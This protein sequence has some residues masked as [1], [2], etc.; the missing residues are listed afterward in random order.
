MSAP[1]G[2][3]VV[4]VPELDVAPELVEPYYAAYRRFAR[5]GRWDAMSS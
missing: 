5:Y 1:D 3:T 2:Q 4:Q